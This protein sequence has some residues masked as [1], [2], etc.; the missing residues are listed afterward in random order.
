MHTQGMAHP[1][2]R[3]EVSTKD[4]KVLRALLPGGVQ[5]SESLCAL[6]RCGNWPR[7][8]A[9]SLSLQL[10]HSRRKAERAGQFDWWARKP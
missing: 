1:V 8:S 5:R 6:W 7:V 9:H 10:F 2:L 4:E 3:F